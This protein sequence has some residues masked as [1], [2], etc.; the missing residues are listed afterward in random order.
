MGGFWFFGALLWGLLL[1]APVVVSARAVWVCVTRPRG[2]RAEAACE[3]CRYKVAG[4]STFTCPECGTDL[5]RTGIITGPME[6]RRRGSM[7]GGVA[8][9][10]FGA[11][12]IGVAGIAGSAS[13]SASRGV[14][15]MNLTPRVTTMT[16]TP[17]SGSFR[18]ARFV[19]T[20]DFSKGYSVQLVLTITSNDGRTAIVQMDESSPDSPSYSGVGPDGKP[21]DIN[22]LHLEES[23]LRVALQSL[24]L[25]TESPSG[26][27]E[28]NALAE[29]TRSIYLNRFGSSRPPL[30]SPGLTLGSSSS[31]GGVPG[32]PVPN[33]AFTFMFIWAV[34]VGLAWVIGLVLI[35]LRRANLMAESTASQPGVGRPPSTAPSGSATTETAASPL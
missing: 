13:V 16:Y 33:S 3:R 2:S 35:I 11:L 10:T 31:S 6:M 27:A 28:H 19:H 15:S 17:D 20:T 30:P 21:L 7:V 34:I 29:V 24:G 22:N 12:L 26:R 18:D 5:R 23:I 8:G 25:S 14:S 4:L 9:W 1:I 32:S